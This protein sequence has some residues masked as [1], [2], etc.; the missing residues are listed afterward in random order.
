MNKNGLLYI[1]LLLQ[2]SACRFFEKEEQQQPDVIARA[3]EKQLYVSDLKNIVPRGAS[4]QDSIAIVTSYINN[5]MKQQ[6]VL[7]KAEDNL[8]DQQKDVSRKLEE[9]RNS[10][11]T[12]IY[13]SELIRQK[14][15]TSVTEEEIKAYYNDHQAN[16]LLKDNIV[17]ATYVKVPLN[18]PKLEKVRTWY[19]SSNSRD[20]SLLIDY[21][22]QFASD[23]FLGTDDWLLFDELL[24]KV[25]IKT[26]DKEEYL[27]N[28][29]FIEVSD[30]SGIYFINIKGF[31]IKESISPLSFERDNIYS[32]IINKRKLELIDAMEK[33]AFDD[34][35]RNNNIKI[36]D[37]KK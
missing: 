22:H 8:N 3:F 16:F 35:V 29:R 2:L 21:C 5:W 13:E 10:L 30:T 15:D 19:K 25:P 28:N 33:S 12:Y 26:Y 9:Y 36:Y 14:L 27:R 1:I 7:Q 34:A 17:K 23:F 20:S 18:A 6:V 11:I 31:K 4:H 37:A 24:K 32:L